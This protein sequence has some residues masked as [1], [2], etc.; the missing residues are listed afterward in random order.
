MEKK[1]PKTRMDV[2][3][4]KEERR[5]SIPLKVRRSLVFARLSESIPACQK[6]SDVMMGGV[7]DIKEASEKKMLSTDMTS[8]R[9]ASHLQEGLQ[10]REREILL[11][12][13]W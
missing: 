7:E 12:G 6:T 13:K 9:G 2:G 3:I 1:N 5:L 10:S 8:S 4:Q 11:T